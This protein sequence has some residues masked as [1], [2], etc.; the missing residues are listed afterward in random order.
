MRTIPQDDVTCF[1]FAFF[2]KK[3]NF[4]T[5]FYGWGSTLSRLQSHFEE[6]VYFLP[7]ISQELLLLDWSTS[8]GWKDELTLEPPNGFELETCGLSFFTDFDFTAS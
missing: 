5:P 8:D 1:C 2:L 3:N 4:R 6:T 7:F